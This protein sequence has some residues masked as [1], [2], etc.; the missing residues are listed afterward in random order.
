MFCQTKLGIG[1][2]G[3]LL[4]NAFP[5]V[6]E[7]TYEGIIEPGLPFLNDG[8]FQAA[9]VGTF[10]VYWD[11]CPDVQIVSSCQFPLLNAMT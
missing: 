7:L 1:V 10:G 3:R 5:R 8:H 2:E 6:E 9:I 11:G 4:E